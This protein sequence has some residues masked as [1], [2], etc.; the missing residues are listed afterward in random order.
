MAR[1]SFIL[2]PKV[3]A[4]VPAETE[5]PRDCF[6]MIAIWRK[7]CQ[8]SKL[9]HALSR[10]L[11]HQTS[12]LRKVVTKLRCL[13]VSTPVSLSGDPEPLCLCGDRFTWH[14]FR[15]FLQ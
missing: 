8:L 13:L 14:V 9:P 4:A 6:V 15:S 11:T 12:T 2:S 10:P 5:M 1:A 3:E 7:Y